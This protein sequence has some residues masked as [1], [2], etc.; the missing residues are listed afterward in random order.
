MLLGKHDLVEAELAQAFR[1]AQRI[2]MLLVALMEVGLPVFALHVVAVRRNDKL[3]LVGQ[4][5]I[6]DN[7]LFAIRIS[8]S[9][10]V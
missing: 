8:I 7:L 3:L 6:H 1:P 5:E 10:F 4:F 9:V 2:L